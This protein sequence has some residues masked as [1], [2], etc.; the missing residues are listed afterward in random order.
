MLHTQITGEDEFG[1]VVCLHAAG[2]S[3]GMWRYIGD[4]LNSQ[5]MRVVRPD[6]PGHG[7]SKQV[8]FETIEQASALVAILIKDLCGS[9]PV[10]VIGLSLGAYV[11]F[12]LLQ[13]YPNLVRRAVLSGFHIMPMPN[14]AMM[15]L[16]GDLMSPLG[17]SM[18]FRRKTAHTLGIPDLQLQPAA[19]TIE[20][21]SG[22]TL[23]A[24]NRAAIDFRK[25]QH[26]DHIRTPLLAVAG[27]REH[28]LIRQ[29]MQVLEQEMPNCCGRIAPELG[30]GWCGE[31]PELFSKAVLSWLLERKVADFLVPA[32]SN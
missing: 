7:S 32:P 13:R 15:R 30:H 9:K 12:D 18:W 1:T 6:L 23:R 4:R 29:S 28:A 25:P 10:H 8:P 19:R 16:V 21:L 26:L 3:N 11:G 20:P 17:A 14:P 24:V 31:K 27:G 2:F 22:R 5:G